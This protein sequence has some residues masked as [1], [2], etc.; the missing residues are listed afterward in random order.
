[1]RILE[2]TRN[3]EEDTQKKFQNSRNK[4]IFKLT[5]LK[6]TNKKTCQLTSPGKM[7]E[8]ISRKQNKN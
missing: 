3:G 8:L 7:S 6:R 2:E 4:E 5:G 1:M